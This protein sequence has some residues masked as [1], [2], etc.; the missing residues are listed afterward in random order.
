MDVAAERRFEQDWDRQGRDV[1]SELSCA[2]PLLS[3]RNIFKS[4][5]FFLIKIIRIVLN[6]T[7]LNKFTKSFDETLHYIEGF[8][9]LAWWSES[10]EGKN[11]SIF[12][13]FNF[14][15]TMKCSKVPNG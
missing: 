6:S 12:C 15:T 2:K 13:A 9:G 3:H 4:S 5:F 7:F 14:N 11:N 1:L 8:K 10:K